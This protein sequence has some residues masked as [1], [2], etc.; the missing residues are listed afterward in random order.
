MHTAT[1]P[2]HNAPGESLIKTV[3]TRLAGGGRKELVAE[4]AGQVITDLREFR[5]ALPLLIHAAG[6]R[7]RP[8]TLT[9]GDYILT[10]EIC[11]ERKSVLDLI[12]SFN[13]GRLYT[14]C[15]LMSVH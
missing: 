3:S 4:G 10:P 14:Q 2:N 5:S 11:V 8:A 1:N 7:V 6:L 9:V 13:S 15:E 12:A